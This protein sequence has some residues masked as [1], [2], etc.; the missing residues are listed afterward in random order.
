[1]SYQVEIADPKRDYDP[2]ANLLN[3][4]EPDPIAATDIREWDRR[5][6]ENILRRSIVRSDASNIIGYSV[7]LQGPWN[8]PGEF[9]LWLCTHP[10]HREQGI[11][12]QLYDHALAFIQ[13][14]SGTAITSEVA[15]DEPKGLQFAKARGFAQG[16]HTF[17]SKLDLHQVDEQTFVGVVAQAEANGIHFY[18][19]ADVE[20]TE[21][22]RRNLYAIN[23]RTSLQ[24]PGSEG[25]FP[26]FERFSKDVFSAPWYRAAGQLLAA[27]GDRIVGMCAVGYFQ[28]SN[29]M[30]NMMTGVDEAYRGRGIAQAL[31]VLAICWAKAYGAD[32]IRTHNNSENAPM[33]AINRKLG[34]QPEPGVYTLTKQLTPKE[35]IMT[36][37]TVS[38]D[39][40]ATVTLREITEE[41]LRDILR[42]KVAPEQEQFVAN[43]AV[44]IAQ[45]HFSK[46]AWFRAIYA[47]ETPVGFAMLYDEPEKSEYFLWRF[48]IDAHYQKL[49][50]GRQALQLVIK[51]VRTRPNA[52]EFFLSY[53][54]EEGGPKEFYESL[55]FLHTGEEDDGELVMRLAL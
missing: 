52:T 36:E 34:Y 35:S 7:A 13:S 4:F 11:G 41:T 2:L 14:H 43:N 3:L 15:E 33:L 20:D 39:R 18:T 29:S 27:D 12:Q 24:D 51:H 5:N 44:S 26:S 10:K 9:Y 21:E 25:K 16:K 17:Q 54:P 1:M 45:A 31:K 47:D 28:E 23:R 19:L 53:V 40:N 6:E 30:Y 8:N 46:H 49:G 38:P 37:T 42:L 55:G 48:M 50:F 22:A 32:H